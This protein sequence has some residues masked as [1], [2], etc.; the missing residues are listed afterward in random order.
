[1]FLRNKF[2][3]VRNGR[4][5]RSLHNQTTALD[6]AHCALLWITD[7]YC[8][9]VLRGQ[10]AERGPAGAGQAHARAPAEG[11]VTLISFGKIFDKNIVSGLPGADGDGR[12]AEP[13]DHQ[14]GVQQ[15]GPRHHHQQQA[16]AHPRDRGARRRRQAGQVH[17]A[18][19]GSHSA[20]YPDLRGVDKFIFTIV[21]LLTPKVDCG[22]VGQIYYFC[23]IKKY[24]C[25]TIFST[26]TVGDAVV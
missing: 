22:T 14:A 8:A 13:V 9:G 10:Q 19:N 25:I 18:G 17:C 23:L 24:Y 4:T 1:M 2:R 16:G 11:W 26:T 3:F 12:V 6:N 5:G 7:I 20:K 21:S 15:P